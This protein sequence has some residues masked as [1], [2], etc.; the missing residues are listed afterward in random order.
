MYNIIHETLGDNSILNY[1]KD[2]FK[3]SWNSLDIKKY[4]DHDFSEILGNTI[5]HA[6]FEYSGLIALF[7]IADLLEN[8]FLNKKKKITI[9]WFKHSPFTEYEHSLKNVLDLC[10]LIYPDIEIK[11]IYID[12]STKLENIN[13]SSPILVSTDFSHHNYVISNKSLYEVWEN[14]KKSFSLSKNYDVK[15]SVPCGNQP[16]RIYKEWI[17]KNNYKFILT[18]YSNSSDKENWWKSFDKSIFSGVTYGIL[19]TIKPSYNDWLY[20]LNSKLLSYSHLKWVDDI[21]KDKELL[22][23]GLM[24]S[25]LNNKQGSCFITIS[26][27]NKNTF[28]CFGNWETNNKNLLEALKKTTINLKKYSWNKN[29]SISKDILKKYLNNNY[30][31]SITLIEPLKNWKK[32]DNNIDNIVKYRGYV[33]YDDIQN[34]VGMTYIPSVW[35][36]INSINEFYKGLSDK[37]YNVYRKNGTYNWNLYMYEAVTWSLTNI[38]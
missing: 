19:S 18:G 32:I 10:Y 1:L 31:I 9:L 24:W 35:D 17:E 30:I 14:D 36:N 27:I 4:S 38:S 23:D 11:N 28:S 6:G 21:I 13:I 33:F 37:H 22:I 25:P 16:L 5:P 34:R 7:A 2:N 26:D 15:E 29:P 8:T 12:H 3:N 20:C